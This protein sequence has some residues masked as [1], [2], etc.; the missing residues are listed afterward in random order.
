[1]AK[2]REFMTNYMKEE[3]SVDRQLLWKVKTVVADLRTN[4]NK[5]AQKGWKVMTVIMIMKNVIE[6]NYNRT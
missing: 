5:L 4:E 2:G 1:M 3:L 6:S